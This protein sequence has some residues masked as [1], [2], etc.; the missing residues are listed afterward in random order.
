MNTFKKLFLLTCCSAIALPALAQDRSLSEA[1]INELF[2]Q[3]FLK[4]ELL[5]D[6]D[7]VELEDKQREEIGGEILQHYTEEFSRKF[8]HRVIA[9]DGTI[10]EPFQVSE[11]R[12]WY[13]QRLIAEK[14]YK[15]LNIDY[16]I[17]DI[18]LMGQ[19]AIAHVNVIAT[20]K[21]DLTDYKHDPKMTADGIV[22]SECE[23]QIKLDFDDMPRITYENCTMKTLIS[24]IDLIEESDYKE[25]A[26]Y[27][28]NP[29]KRK[30]EYI[31]DGFNPAQFTN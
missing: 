28:V 24:N 12:Y 20:Y 3:M 6:T 16:K 19:R 4:E 7:D 1:E 11:N 26:R 30:A 25:A 17:K 13:K 10:G 8:K 2:E 29:P 18:E 15:N 9:D 23:Y 21:S 31:L 14:D 27:M 5:I 22:K